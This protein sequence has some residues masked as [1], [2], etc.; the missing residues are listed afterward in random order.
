MRLP[1]SRLT[2]LLS[3]I[4]FL[5]FGGFTTAQTIVIPDT[6]KGWEDNWVVNLNGA[7]AS[8]D[9][10]SEGGVNTIS[11]TFSTNYSKI[12]R[13]DLFAF[14]IRINGRYGQARLNDDTRKSDDLLTIRTRSTFGFS[15]R[16]RLSAYVRLCYAHSFETVSSTMLN[17]IPQVLTR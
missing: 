4:L 2:A 14:G 5:F 11:G 16:T 10:W 12:Y 1:Y 13:G 17:V 15:D 9:N 6:L 8:F 7:Q 3:F